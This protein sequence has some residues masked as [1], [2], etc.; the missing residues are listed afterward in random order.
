MSQKT[1]QLRHQALHDGLT[2]LPNRALILDRVDQAL[3][4]S[5][6]QKSSLAVMFLDLDGFKDVNDTLGHAAGDQLLRG[7]SARLRRLLRDNDTVGRLG[8]DEFVVVIEGYSLDAG[9]EVVAERIREVL[10]SRS[11]WPAPKR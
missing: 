10:A 7:V 9:P 5:R 6:R 1:E 2:G 4:R 8:G 3:A 11:S